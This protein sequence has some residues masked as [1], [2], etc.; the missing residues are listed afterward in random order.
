VVLFATLLLVGLI[1]ANLFYVSL[2]PLQGNFVP[3]W[4]G[5]R[6]FLTRGL[7]PYSTE[8]AGEIQKTLLASDQTPAPGQQVFLAPFYSFIFYTPFALTGNIA[9][10]RVAWMTLL[11]LAIL[12]LLALSL[13]LSR[14]RTPAWALVLLLIFSFTWYYGLRPLL[15]GDLSILVALGAAFALLAIRVEQD[16][17]AGFVL[18]L[19]MIRPAPILPLVVFVLVWAVANQRWTIFW[20]FVGSLTLIV[21]ATSLLIPDWVAQYLRQLVQVARTLETNTPGGLVAYW[22]PGIGEAFGRM[23]SILTVILLVFEW[24]RALRKDFRWFFWTACLTLAVTP[25]SG[26]PTSLDN[27]IAI[28]PGLVLVLATWDERWGRLGKALVVA[29]LLIL[30]V[31]AWW[32]VS[33]A[34]QQ[35]MLPDLNPW[36]FFLLP[37]FMLV[38]LYWV[39]WWAIQPPRLPLNEMASQL[40]L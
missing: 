5:T 25:L 23:L 12:A 8:T 7:S 38:G 6:L 1:W 39:R 13:N 30:S 18:A 32:L 21:A 40:N 29:S 9:A 24:S 2:D 10:A 37:S 17:L 28:F 11:E 36:L 15:D 16:A 27:F 22:L 19:A 3:N 14:W 4:L 26:I 33:Y 34:T 31:G 20:G 35:G